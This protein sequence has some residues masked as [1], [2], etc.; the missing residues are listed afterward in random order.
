MPGWGP[1][2]ARE[3]ARREAG[4]LSASA[5]VS[6]GGVAQPEAPFVAGEALAQRAGLE[7]EHLGRVVMG[8]AEPTSSIARRA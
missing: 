8:A 1:R 6:A 4:G 3:T 5:C 2:S 7:A